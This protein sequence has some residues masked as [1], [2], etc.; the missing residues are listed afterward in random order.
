MSN[1]QFHIVRVFDGIINTSV[2]PTA[3]IQTVVESTRGR[4]ITTSNSRFF[5]F[6]NSDLDEFGTITFLHSLDRVFVDYSVFM[7]GVGEVSADSDS[8]SYNN[9]TITL[10]SYQPIVGNWS[11]LIEV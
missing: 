4:G 8:Y 9:L 3:P 1:S 5:N 11:I 2:K 10:K 7:P 6:T